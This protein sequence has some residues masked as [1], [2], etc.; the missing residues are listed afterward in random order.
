MSTP[1]KLPSC[2]HAEQ[3]PRPRFFGLMKA[4]VKNA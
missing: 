2:A 4:K 3:A 1:T